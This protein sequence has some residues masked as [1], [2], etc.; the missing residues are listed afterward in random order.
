MVDVVERFVTGRGAPQ[1]PAHAFL[2]PL[3][4]VP[5]EDVA[6]REEIE[7]LM[8]VM[9]SVA[10]RRDHLTSDEVDATLRLP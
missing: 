5:M 9:A 6:L 3:R 2:V 4:P 10:D 8:D 7:L 1:V